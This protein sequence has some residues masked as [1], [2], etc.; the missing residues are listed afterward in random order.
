MSKK[1]PLEQRDSLKFWANQ[2]KGLLQTIALIDEEIERLKRG[3]ELVV[4][5]LGRIPKSNAFE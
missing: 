3:R 5:S 2:R 1:L 4:K